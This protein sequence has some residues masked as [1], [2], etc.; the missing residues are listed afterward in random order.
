M[1]GVALRR[2]D[3]IA[4]AVKGEYLGKPRP[5][6]I[7]Q[8]DELIA[9]RDSISLCPLTSEL[10]GAAFRVRIER[11]TLNGLQRTSDVMADKI[12]TVSKS[13]IQGAPFGRVTEAQLQRVSDALREWL[14][15]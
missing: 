4:V 11:S 8:A 7:V 2:G 15:L 1:A 12:L 6:L 10:V 14:G 5:A 13:R 3:L 9:L